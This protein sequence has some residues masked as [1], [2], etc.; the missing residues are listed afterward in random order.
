[1]DRG[2]TELEEISLDPHL[3]LLYWDLIPTV[4]A[5]FWPHGTLHILVPPHYQELD[6]LA[7]LCALD[8]SVL[9]DLGVGL[10]QQRQCKVH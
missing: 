4:G 10:K 5:R 6:V 1:M 2:I 3:H 9:T 8:V 7:T